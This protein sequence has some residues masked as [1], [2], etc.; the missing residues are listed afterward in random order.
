M[1]ISKSLINN[2]EVL[3]GENDCIKFQIAPALGGKI[4]SIYNKNLK[5]EFLWSN[6]NLLV[7][8]N[9]PDTDYDSNFWGGIDELIPN[10]IPETVDGIEYP[11]HG[12]LWTTLLE[13]ELTNVSI[14]V[15]GMLEKSE[16]FYKKTIYF[17]TDA[18]KINLHYK[19]INKSSAKRHF[20]WKLH[21][22]LNISEGDQLITP[23]ERAR[24]VYPESSRFDNSEEFQWPF[25][26]GTDAS[27]VPVKNNK[28]DFFYLYDSP[29]GEM[30]LIMDQEKYIFSYDYDQAVFPYQWYFASYGKFRNHYTVILEPASAMP[31]SVNEAAAIKQCTILD[32][33]EEINTI[34]TIYAGENNLVK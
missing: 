28:M 15:F 12:E 2:I 13:Y 19:I 23:A 9:K 29:R 32:P 25:I 5:K 30:R 14:S 7:E 26:N 34:V 27:I 11:D 18:S 31:V 10:D 4:L 1:I 20:L 6:K 16:F 8:A 24:I 3:T 17:D 33:D 22:A 21:A